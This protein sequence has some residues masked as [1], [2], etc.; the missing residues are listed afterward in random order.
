MPMVASHIRM[1]VLPETLD[2]IVVRTVGR[3]E[4]ESNASKPSQGVAG[5]ATLVDAVVV[6]NDVDALGIGIVLSQLL[7][8]LDE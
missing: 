8:K 2:A 3:K 5:L 6:Q 4:V 1:E 7:K